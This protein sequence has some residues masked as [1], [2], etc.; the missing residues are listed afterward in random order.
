MWINDLAASFSKSQDS[1]AKEMWETLTI[2]GC[3]MS[4]VGF[5]AQFIGLRGLTYP[6]AIAHI[7]SILLMAIVRGFVRRRLGHVPETMNSIAGSELEHLA[8]HIVSCIKPHDNHKPPNQS[9]CSNTLMSRWGVTSVKEP[10]SSDKHAV[11][12][13]K[14]LEASIAT[15][16]NDLCPVIRDVYKSAIS[17][18]L[19][20]TRKR[21][22]DLCGW[23][24]K[25]SEVSWSLVRSIEDFMKTFFPQSPTEPSND[26]EVDW[27]LETFKPGADGT[28]IRDLA[29]IPITKSSEG[30]KVDFGIVEAIISLWMANIEAKLQGNKE[31][32]ERKQQERNQDD[33]RR[34]RAQHGLNP[35]FCRI[36]GGDSE[37]GLLR[38]DLSWWVNELIADQSKDGD[39]DGNRISDS[40]IRDANIVVGFHGSSSQAHIYS[41]PVDLL[42]LAT[43]EA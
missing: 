20:M 6:C 36:I 32:S 22:G 25:A 39:R 10:N 29:T 5:T 33:W 34:T 7:F 16:M 12:S 3:S 2:V 8:M 17:Q 35:K 21:L 15:S 14:D 26:I 37:E 13:R 23:D 41:I 19:L 18:A 4:I 28:N 1:Y 43:Q 24:S 27:V 30:Y 31:S 11:M 42:T 38:R 9:E 40:N